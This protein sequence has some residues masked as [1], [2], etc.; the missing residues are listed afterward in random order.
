MPHHMR[1][2]GAVR[3]L[4]QALPPRYVLEQVHKPPGGTAVGC[5]S[6]LAMADMACVL[7]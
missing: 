1:H 3:L 2:V 4:L 6:V 7:G 5:W